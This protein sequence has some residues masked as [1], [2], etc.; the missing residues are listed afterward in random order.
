MSHDRWSARPD[1]G[2]DGERRDGDDL[3]HLLRV[4][5][6]GYEPD[7]AAIRARLN[8]VTSSDGPPSGREGG[9]RHRR[10]AL[11]GLISA[12]AA[13]AVVVALVARVT[14][15]DDVQTVSPGP[16]TTPSTEPTVAT[17]GSPATSS[18]LPTQPEATV[19]ST[20]VPTTAT[21]AT[22]PGEA[23]GPAPGGASP[24][25]AGPDPGDG[26][27]PAPTSSGPGATPVE[28]TVGALPPQLSLSAA[29]YLDWAITGSRRDGKV[30]TLDDQDALLT[31][32]VVG[33]SP[34]WVEAPIDILWTDGRPEEDRTENGHWWTT[35]G[36][37]EVRIPGGA[38]AT[39]LS[40]YV[41][42]SGSVTATV[43]VVGHPPVQG[44]VPAGAGGVVMVR[45]GPGAAGTDVAIVLSS[46]SGTGS[47]ALGAVTAR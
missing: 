1:E 30:I 40:L 17:S 3:R 32:Q 6:A 5:S 9:S 31:V 34:E 41:G 47:V 36:S 14:P 18:P 44:A 2:P 42:G 12:A 35:S 8:A 11:V 13:V 33:P 28:V 37:F 38:G 23:D 4:Y 25:S 39:E 15:G 27:T 45:L 26:A 19:P 7:R 43:T 22:S 29:G 46:G 20:T 10:S 21:A 16:T 24:G